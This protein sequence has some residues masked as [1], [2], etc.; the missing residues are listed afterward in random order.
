LSETFGLNV[1]R[2]SESLSLEELSETF[3]L[4]VLRES[5]SLSL[6]DSS[7]S[8]GTSEM[9]IGCQYVAILTNSSDTQ[10]QRS[11]SHVQTLLNPLSFVR[12]LSR[13]LSKK[14]HEHQ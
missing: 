5:E 4:N 9:S 6:E 12:N 8:I 1:L 13:L 10:G 14:R 2:E 11:T 3:G 7:E